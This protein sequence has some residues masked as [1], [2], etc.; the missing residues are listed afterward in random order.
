MNLLL[1]LVSFVSL[2]NAVVPRR[3]SSIDIGSTLDDSKYLVQENSDMEERASDDTNTD[4]DI[5]EKVVQ[6]IIQVLKDPE[7]KLTP[8]QLRLIPPYNKKSKT[9]HQNFNDCATEYEWDQNGR[10]LRAS[11]TSSQKDTIF[12]KLQQFADEILERT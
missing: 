7:S 3:L 10:R 5:C 2:L 4:E 12:P 6:F 11:L 1:V 8:E 9:Q